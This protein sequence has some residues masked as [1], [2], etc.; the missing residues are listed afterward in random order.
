[1]K[2]KYES[3]PASR[4]GAARRAARQSR[5]PSA[6]QDKAWADAL[7]KGD[8]PEKKGLEKEAFDALWDRRIRAKKFTALKE[9]CESELKTPRPARTAKRATG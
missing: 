5:R 4:A 2:T 9:R 6:G 1:M 8:A 7:A 3:G